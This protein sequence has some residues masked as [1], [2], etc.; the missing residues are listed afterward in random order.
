M[1]LIEQEELAQYIQKELNQYKKPQNKN[2]QFIQQLMEK[3]EA[4]PSNLWAMYAPTKSLA[5]KFIIVENKLKAQEYFENYHNKTTVDSLKTIAALCY[6]YCRIVD[7]KEVTKLDQNLLEQWQNAFKPIL[8]E[9]NN[10]LN[11]VIQ[12]TNDFVKKA[13]EDRIQKINDA[14]NNSITNQKP[15][16]R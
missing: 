1:D 8:S 5:Y 13:P 9:F 11:K 10:E 4:K 16:L 15:K 12:E 3:A 7:G 2:E 14:L 6:S